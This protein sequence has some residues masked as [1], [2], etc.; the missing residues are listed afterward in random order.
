[1]ASAHASDEAPTAADLLAGARSAAGGRAWDR[2]LA[3]HAEGRIAT[4]GL[5]GTWREVDDLR[6][7]RFQSAADVGLYRVSEGFD[8]RKRWRQDPSGGVHALDAPFSR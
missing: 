5:T 2:V 4:S 6:G 1:L 8:G 3:L 7:G